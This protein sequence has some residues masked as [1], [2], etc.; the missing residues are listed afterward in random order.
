V[1]TWVLAAVLLLVPATGGAELYRWIASDGTV[2]YTAD[3]ESIPPAWRTEAESLGHPQ[4]RPAPV[5]EPDSGAVTV[6]WAADAPVVVEARLNGV[7]LTLMLDTGADRTLISP[8]ALARAGLLA[9]GTPVQLTG[10]TGTA[11]ATLVMLPYLDVAGFRLG[12]FPVV[13]HAMPPSGVNEPAPVD[14]LL[15]RD[16]LDAFTITVD[17]GSGRTRLVPR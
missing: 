7:V 9:E 6:P 3:R 15:G 17:P 11:A 8:E 2:H 12:P 1:R 5:P 13:V 4:A 10:V 16:L 14:G